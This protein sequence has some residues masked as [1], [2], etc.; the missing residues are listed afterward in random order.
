MK[1]VN[2]YEEA[3]RVEKLQN[4]FQSLSKEFN[5]ASL[6]LKEKGISKEGNRPNDDEILPESYL[7]KINSEVERINQSNKPKIYT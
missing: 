2:P 5:E 3:K 1:T 6:K 7:E 4:E